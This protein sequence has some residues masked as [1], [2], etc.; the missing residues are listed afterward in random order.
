MTKSLRFVLLILCLNGCVYA[1]R[2][3]HTVDDRPS[4][5]VVNA[6]SNA[7][8]HV[9]GSEVGPASKFDG[10]PTILLLE[11]G[12]HHVEIRQESNVIRS[13]DVFLGEGTRREIR[14]PGGN[15]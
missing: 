4:L 9:D 6:P 12:T 14:L 5:F 10:N 8:L 15:P 3:T 13:L 2:Q 7:T 11:P 1:N